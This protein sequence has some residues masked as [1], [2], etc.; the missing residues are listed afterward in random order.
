MS[1]PLTPIP[2]RHAD[3]T[4]KLPAPALPD[5]AVQT[6]GDQSI[7]GTKTHTDPVKLAA[8][9]LIA[10]HP[11]ISTF[12]ASCF[13]FDP[14][15]APAMQIGGSSLIDTGS[16][17]DRVHFVWS[18]GTNLD[19]SNRPI[20][21]TKS[22]C[23]YVMEYNYW[24]PVGLGAGPEYTHEFHLP[25]AHIVTAPGVFEELR[26]LTIAVG[27]SS[28]KA[29]VLV[30]ASSFFIGDESSTHA[31]GGYNFDGD[32]AFWNLLYNNGSGPDGTIYSFAGGKTSDVF[33][34]GRGPVPATKI[35]N[36]S[37][38]AEQLQLGGVTKY[39]RGVDAANNGQCTL[40]GPTGTT[41]ETSWTATGVSN[42]WYNERIRV[43]AFGTQAAQFQIGPDSANTIGLA[44]KMATSQVEDAIK[45]LDAGGSTVFRVG[46]F[47]SLA[48]GG[49]ANLLK[50]LT[51]TAALDFP[52]TASGATSDLTISLTGA[53][54]GDVVTLGGGP[55][56]RASGTGFEAWVSATDTV[57]VRFWNISG[58]AVDPAS[59]TFRVSI[60]KF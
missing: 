39:T 20:D 18:I 36:G 2:A 55:A 28:R 57:T 45:I 19:G 21:P 56:S 22:Y 5:E 4:G 27:D 43:G 10:S 58:S 26:P 34:F 51:A 14:A 25:A 11:A 50:H 23:R 24:N 41:L 48:V 32:T 7:A 8:T 30:N 3:L 54:L 16:P 31:K 47:G 42:K 53:A 17:G 59:A 37:Q 1:T 60:L 33:A 15:T 6:T 46:P 52:S 38:I 44:F 9:R 49:G 35:H 12:G 40:I 29:V 13:T